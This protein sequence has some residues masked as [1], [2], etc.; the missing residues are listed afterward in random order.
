[1]VHPWDKIE[2]RIEVNI[3]HSYFENGTEDLRRH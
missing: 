1:M 3:S 2:Q